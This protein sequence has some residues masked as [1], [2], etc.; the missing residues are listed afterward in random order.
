MTT[1]GTGLFDESSAF[2]TAS[3][4]LVTFTFGVFATLTLGLLATFTLGLLPT[5]T[6][7]CTGNGTFVTA[8]GKGLLAAAR[9]SLMGMKAKASKA[10]PANPKKI[11]TIFF[12]LSSS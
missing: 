1:T 2:D 4:L 11:L 3:A 9:C 5:E 8:T 7:P 6:V 10:K 12:I